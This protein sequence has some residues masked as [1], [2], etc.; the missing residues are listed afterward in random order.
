MKNITFLFVML[1]ITLFATNNASAQINISGKWK[2]S[3]LDVTPPEGKQFTPEQAT[4]AVEYKKRMFL[5]CADVIYD[6]EGGTYK[7]IQAGNEESVE[8]GTYTLEGENEFLLIRKFSISRLEGI[9]HKAKLKGNQLIIEVM[10]NVE[11]KSGIEKFG[12]GVKCMI[13]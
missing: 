8:N 13:F 9:Q 6:F 3:T 2:V 12:C 11:G 10:A 1:L 4:S 5:R 7:L